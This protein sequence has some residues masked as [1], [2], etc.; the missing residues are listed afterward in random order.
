MKKS[1]RIILTLV[2]TLVLVATLSAAAFAATRVEAE[3]SF[4]HFDVVATASIQQYSANV[5][6]N[7]DPED[8][9]EL[10]R[11]EIIGTYTYYWIFQQQ[12]TE[13]AIIADRRTFDRTSYSHTRSFNSN[14]DNILSMRHASFTVRDEI[15]TSRGTYYFEPDALVVTYPN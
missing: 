7:V 8:E 4:Y 1:V 12:D 13:Y 10:S 2:L 15:Y 9:I 14:Q 6:V 3:E 5:T 11:G